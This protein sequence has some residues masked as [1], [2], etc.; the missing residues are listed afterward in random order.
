ML[1]GPRQ[2]VWL[3]AIQQRITTTV[4]ALGSIKGVK[5]TGSTDTIESIITELRTDEIQRS[6]KFRELLIG[7]VT[8]CKCTLLRFLSF[9]G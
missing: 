8:L 1:L 5:A 9:Y 6:K 3:E 2:K 7:L 4:A